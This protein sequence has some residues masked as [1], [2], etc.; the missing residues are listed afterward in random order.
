MKT[1]DIVEVIQSESDTAR[2]ICA[3]VGCVGVIIHSQLGPSKNQDRF[4]VLTNEKILYLGIDH[5]KVINE[6]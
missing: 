4:S 6:S 2:G 3:H 5:L 1:G